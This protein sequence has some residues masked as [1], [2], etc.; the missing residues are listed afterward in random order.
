MPICF[1][2]AFIFTLDRIVQPLV[3][4]TA[5]GRQNSVTGMYAP[6]LIQVFGS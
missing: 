3:F 1:P 2:F 5:G 6:D 4:K